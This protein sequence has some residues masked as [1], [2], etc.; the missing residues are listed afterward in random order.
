MAD[1]FEDFSDFSD[2]ELENDYLSESYLED[3]DEL[4]DLFTPAFKRSEGHEDEAEEGKPDQGVSLADLIDGYQQNG[5][6]TAQTRKQLNELDD[7]QQP[8]GKPLSRLQ[9]KV[10]DR[11]VS[12]EEESRSTSTWL[13][14]IQRNRKSKM[15]YPYR[16]SLAPK[17]TLKSLSNINVKS[18]VATDMSEK[19]NSLLSGAGLSKP[20]DGTFDNE[21]IDDD[22]SEKMRQMEAAESGREKALLLHAFRKRK[23]QKKIKSRRYRKQLRKGRVEQELTEEEM[24]KRRILERATLRHKTSNS[25]FMRRQRER[26]TQEHSDRFK[27]TLKQQALLDQELRERMEGSEPS[28]FEDDEFNDDLLR[29]EIADLATKKKLDASTKADIIELLEADKN[30][31]LPNK[32]LMSLGFMKKAIKERRM[33][34]DED[35]A[36]A[37]AFGTFS[38]DEEELVPVDD[39]EVTLFGNVSKPIQFT[40]SKPVA[41][42]ED[43]ESENESEEEKSE[44]EEEEKESEA[45][46]EI[47]ESDLHPFLRAGR[48]EKKRTKTQQPVKK[49]TLKEMAGVDF[50]DKDDV[51]EE[52]E[53]LETADLVRDVFADN[54][55]LNAD[56]F[57]KN[58]QNLIDETLPDDVE[59]VPGWGF[60]SGPGTTKPKKLPKHLRKKSN[61]IKAIRKE[62]KEQ[63]KDKNNER[64]ILS[65]KSMVPDHYKAVVKDIPHY[66]SHGKYENEIKETVGRETLTINA[67]EQKIQPDVDVAVGEIIDP[68]RKSKRER[69]GSNRRLAKQRENRLNNVSK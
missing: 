51:G 27:E 45:E 23:H 28:D 34:E 19:I 2:G 43:V 63:R 62:I 64:L 53:D 36:E 67:F 11:Q 32:G 66:K 49:Q 38:D 46:V 1:Q 8:A 37:D 50:I 61:K 44:V 4:E 42:T 41:A 22:E 68:I 9:K 24:E 21:G 20:E 56:E 3:A 26:K 29:S 52:E 33:R 25:K 65:T 31:E 12:Y 39:E 40:V 30:I 10:L 13:P 60:W 35:E 54:A 6:V 5:S 7:V 17:S 48:V 18:G 16:P 58:K 57:A 15:Q 59:L 55:G 14:I 69:K 47:E